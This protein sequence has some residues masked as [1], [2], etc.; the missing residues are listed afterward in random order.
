MA[1]YGVEMT[2]RVGACKLQE[3]A[4][5]AAGVLT[6]SEPVSNET[7]ANNDLIRTAIPHEYKG[8]RGRPELVARPPPCPL[9]PMP[10]TQRYNYFCWNVLRFEWLLM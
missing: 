5:P 4:A 7:A 2:T 6:M 1:R 3:P 10:T 9:Y 8:L